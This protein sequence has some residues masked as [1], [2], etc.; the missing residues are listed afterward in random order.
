MS[1][2]LI[3]AKPEDL[4]T[5]EKRGKYKVCIIGCGQ[6]GILHAVLFAEAGFKVICFDSDQTAVNN[7]A[8]GRASYSGDQ[9]QTGLKNHVRAKNMTATNDIKEAV[10]QSNLI[11][12]TIPEKVDSKKKADHSIIE[13]MCKRMAPNLQIGSLIIWAKPVGIG[14]VESTIKDTLENSSG[15][16]VGKDIGLAYSPFHPFSEKRLVAATDKNTLNVTSTILES[17][18]KGGLVK[19]G[20]MK[21]AETAA[22]FDIQRYDVTDA[23]ANELALFCEKTGVDFLEVNDLLKSTSAYPLPVST[24]SNG[25]KKEEP[26]ILLAD[27]ENLNIKLRVAW[28]AR[29]VNEQMAKHVASLV[30]DAMGS[31][32]KTPRRARLVILGRSQTPNMKSPPKRIVKEITQLLASRGARISLYDPYYS[33]GDLADMQFRPKK[34]LAEAVEGADC[35]IILTEHEQFKKLNLKRLKIMMKKSSSIIDLQGVIE[36]DKAEKEGFIYRGL[37]RGVWT[38]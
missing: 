22:L 15:F 8:K 2:P 35:T 6:A 29:E 26:Y 18:T 11:T 25:S 19:T 20:N 10:A 27:A 16:T 17:T 34:S 28:A 33:E 9:I 30:K 7:I 5:T 1:T 24:L 3:H 36:P 12:V 4:N 37:G 38:K 31:C 14:I 32:G 23:L 21:A 13:N